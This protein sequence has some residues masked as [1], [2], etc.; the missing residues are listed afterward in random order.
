MPAAAERKDEW[1]TL[2]AMPMEPAVDQEMRQAA[3]DAQETTDDHLMHI[4][5]R[6]TD[7]QGRR[8]FVIKNSWGP[9]ERLRWR[10]I[11][12]HGLFPTPHHWGYGPRARRALRFAS[13]DGALTFHLSI[14][15]HVRISVPG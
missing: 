4:V 15:V 14:G 3:F 11:R 1:K 12:F 13:A 6:A 8:Y 5:G 10:A 2:G 9:L 7:V